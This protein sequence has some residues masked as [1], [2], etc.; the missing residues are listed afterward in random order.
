MPLIQFDGPELSRN[1][2]AELVEKLTKASQ[3][4]SGLPP[5][6]FTIIIRKSSPDNVG[7]AGKLLP[8]LT[9]DLH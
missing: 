1:K 4:V 2:K 5:Q 7:L 6:A 8:I 3:E 9:N